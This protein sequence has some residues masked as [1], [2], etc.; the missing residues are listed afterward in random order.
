MAVRAI[1]AV[2]H[3][4]GTS[5]A[6][7]PTTT[8]GRRALDTARALGRQLDPHDPRVVR[9]TGEQMVSELF[10]KPMLNEMRAFP[11]GKGILDGGQ[12]ES[13]FGQQLD[14]YLA[15]AAA[16][17]DHGGLTDRIAGWLQ[18]ESAKRADSTAVTAAAAN[19]GAAEEAAALLQ[20]L[21]S[22]PSAP[23]WMQSTPLMPTQG[24]QEGW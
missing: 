3:T 17:G 8:D 23:T 2:T 14:Q 6:V 13:A 24:R 22:G 18:T 4:P 1:S 10:F 15:D 11:L 12:A 9:R 19:G 16:A 5:P 7:R 21:R 20:G